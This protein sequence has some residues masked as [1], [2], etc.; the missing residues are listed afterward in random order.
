VR[1]ASRCHDLHVPQYLIRVTGPSSWPAIPQSGLLEVL[2]PRGYGCQKVNG[3][4]G[5]LRL[6][7]GNCEIVFSGEDV[8]WQ[9][10]FEGDTTGHD[11]DALIS[12]IA[13][14]IEEFTGGRTE[15]MRYG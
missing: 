14:Q 4:P 6:W 12:Q 9:V 11:T 3:P 5:D 10:W 2:E 13:H 1:R 7:L 15:W 8:G